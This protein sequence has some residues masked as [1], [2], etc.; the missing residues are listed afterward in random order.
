MAVQ[1]QLRVYQQP[2]AGAATEHPTHYCLWSGLAK[3]ST[4]M[5]WV[6]TLGKAGWKHLGN[7]T[8][9]V[10]IFS[11]ELKYLRPNIIKSTYLLLLVSLNKLHNYVRFLGSIEVRNHVDSADLFIFSHVLEIWLNWFFNLW[12]MTKMVTFV[13]KSFK[14]CTSENLLLAIF[15]VLMLQSFRKTE[16]TLILSDNYM[17][18][19]NLFHFAP[20]FNNTKRLAFPF[21]WLS[22]IR[23]WANKKISAKY[24]NT[25]IFDWPILIFLWLEHDGG[26]K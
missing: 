22:G 12:R 5:E 6:A 26:M 25:K 17:S 24:H 9:L 10:K 8:G 19:C 16:V 4:R 21:Y 14:A 13:K 23:T 15:L 7:F 3:P 1:S 20:S 11:H 2:G 18:N